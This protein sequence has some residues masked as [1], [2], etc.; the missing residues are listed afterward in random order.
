MNTDGLII[1]VVNPGR[2]V[3]FTIDNSIVLLFFSWT[4]MT[5]FVG[6]AAWVIFVWTW[7]H[8]WVRCRCVRK[9]ICFCQKHPPNYV[10]MGRPPYPHDEDMTPMHT[11]M[12]GIWNGVEEVQQG[13][14][15]RRGGKRLFQFESARWRPKAIQVRA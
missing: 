4:L 12:I 13:C 3:F 8:K 6:R 11:I 15:S 7:V 1:I 2:E 5:S 9:T 10:S 14:P